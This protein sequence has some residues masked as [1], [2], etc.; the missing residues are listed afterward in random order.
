MNAERLHA[1]VKSLRSEVEATQHPGHL[2]ELAS[3]LEALSESPGQPEAQQRVSAAR[4]GLNEVLQ[5]A[6][7]ND[8][9]PV[10]RQALEEMGIADLAGDA[11]LEQIE[12]VLLTNDMTPNTA[13]SQIGEIR[14]RVN[15]LVAGLNEAEQSLTFFGI[16]SEDLTPGEFE[17]GIMIPRKAVN[18]GLGGLGSEFIQLKQIVDTFSELAGENRPE[19][20]V[21]SISSSEFQVFLDSTPA[22]AALIATTLERLMKAYESFLNIRKLHR[23]MSEAGI[24]DENLEGV[25]GYVSGTMEEEIRRIVDE[26]L[27]EAKLDDEGRI[28]ELRKD[29]TIRISGLAERIDNGYDVE[30]RAGALPE[31]SEEGEEGDAL[32]P[33]TQKATETV[34][35][36]QKSLEFMNVEGKAIL[37][38]QPPD[39]SISED[40]QPE[41]SATS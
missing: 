11:L 7:S 6:P 28:N 9:S 15:A 22:V 10:W 5:S 21:R 40:G 41:A 33:D 4:E 16:P 25:S 19:V 17:I 36:A 24:P 13:A 38:L 31:P 27:S 32:D 37:A 1:I 18:N 2:E 35:E 39:D 23:E 30:V 29:L 12:A 20:Q 14:D 34:L 3:G 26:A 8:F